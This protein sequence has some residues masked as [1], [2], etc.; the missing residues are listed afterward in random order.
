MNFQTKSI[1]AVVLVVAVIVVGYFG[2]LPRWND[3]T[4]AK[5][6]L[7]TAQTKQAQLKAAQAQVN[8]F[9]N[10]YKQHSAD[11]KL[12]NSVLPLKQQE[13]YNVLSN[14]DALSKLS[15]VTLGSL[16]TVDSPN[17]DLLGAQANSIQPITVTLGISGTFA[18]FQDFLGRLETSLRIIDLRTLTL[19]TGANDSSGL[20]TMNFTTYYQK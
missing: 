5:D 9:L 12:L 2:V 4:A 6:A 13:F 8:N 16:T 11:A 19:T 7:S 14:L 1:V 20:Y 10:E 15:G 18:S 17:S 3:Y